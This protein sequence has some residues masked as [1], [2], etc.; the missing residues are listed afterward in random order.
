MQMQNVD[1]QI[2]M[3]MLLDNL[4]VNVQTIELG[5]NKRL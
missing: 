2:I 1:Q 4:D 5:K 3:G